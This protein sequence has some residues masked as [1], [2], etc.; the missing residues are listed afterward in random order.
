MRFVIGGAA[1][2]TPVQN[3]FKGLSLFPVQGTNHFV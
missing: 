1:F 3:S 2:T